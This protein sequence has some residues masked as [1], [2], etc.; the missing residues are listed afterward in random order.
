MPTL[1]VTP[2]TA[3]IIC[4][5]GYYS[6]NGT[7]REP[8][9][10]CPIGTTNVGK[11]QNFCNICAK[12]YFGPFG[13]KPCYPCAPGTHSDIGSSEC[14]MCFGNFPYCANVSLSELSL[15]V[16]SLRSDMETVASKNNQ[17]VG[18]YTSIIRK[19]NRLDRLIGIK[20]N[21]LLS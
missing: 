17:I 9:K 18:N 3:S 2:P 10:L 19:L 20:N 6:V 16:D 15:E 7:G 1:Y 14:I 21:Y 8:C 13:R 11:N 5:Q 12:N 4:K